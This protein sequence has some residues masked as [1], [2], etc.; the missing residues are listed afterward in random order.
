MYFD[1]EVDELDPD[2]FIEVV[3]ALEP[4]FGGINLEDI[5]AP[6]CL[7]LSSNRASG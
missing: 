3:A 4:T 6:E 1:I 5:K 7:I 2:K